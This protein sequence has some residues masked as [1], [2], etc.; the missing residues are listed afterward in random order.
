MSLAE[1]D[2]F[3]VSILAEVSGSVRYN[4]MKEGQSIEERT[5]EVTF[6]TRKVIIETRGADLK[7][8]IELLDDSEVS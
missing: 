6:L 2:P 4:D 1:W 5:D 3:A 8:S 7:P